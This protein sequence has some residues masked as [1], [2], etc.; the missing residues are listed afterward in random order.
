VVFAANG[1]IA[2]VLIA[3]WIWAFF[4]VV[5]TESERCRRLPKLA[6]LVIVMLLADLGALLWV[7]IGRPTRTPYRAGETDYAAPRRPIAVEDRPTYAP[8]PGA[9]PAAGA[10]SDRRSAELDRQLDEWE[11]RRRAHDDDPPPSGD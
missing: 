1:A 6:W 2:L 3:F 9:S 8:M 5:V 7:L 10:I 4:D 11:A